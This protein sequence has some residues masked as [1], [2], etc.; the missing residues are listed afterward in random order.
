MNAC[1]EPINTLRPVDLQGPMQCMTGAWSWTACPQATWLA[2]SSS[3]SSTAATVAVATE[4]AT[5]TGGSAHLSGNQGHL[6]RAAGSA[7]P[8]NRWAQGWGVDLGLV[9]G[10]VGNQ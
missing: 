7:C 1:P 2:S 10:L 5:M 8:V 6:W 3:G 9:Q 4:G